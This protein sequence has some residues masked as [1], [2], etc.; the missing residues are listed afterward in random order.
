MYSPQVNDFQ[1]AFTNSV[2]QNSVARTIRVNYD[3][4]L[5]PTMLFHFGAGLLHTSQPNLTPDFDQT[6]LGWAK[7]FAYPRAFP[8]N[9]IPVDASRGGFGNYVMGIFNPYVYLKDI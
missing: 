3:Q 6:S 7:N 4:S 1:Q 8:Y 2:I 9:S 5:T